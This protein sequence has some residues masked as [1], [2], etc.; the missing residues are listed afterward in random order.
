MILTT[1]RS[2]QIEGF[3]KS[4]S[5]DGFLFLGEQRTGK[6]LTSLLVVDHRK[7]DILFIVC[8]QKAILEWEQQIEQHLKIDWDCQIEIVHYEGCSRTKQQRKVW[9]K[10]IRDWDKAGRRIL[11]IGD[12][13]HRIKK[14]GSFQSRFMRSIAPHCRWRLGLTGT[15]IAQGIQDAWALLEFANPDSAGPSDEFKAR[16]LKYGGYKGKKIVGY[17]HKDEFTELLHR[18]SFRLTLNEARREEGKT[19]VRLRRVKIPVELKPDTWRA[20]QEIQEDLETIVGQSKIRVPLL[21]NRAMKLQQITG[22]Y[23]IHEVRVL[24]RVKKKKRIVTVGEEKLGKL[25]EF[26]NNWPRE[27]KIV[28]CARFTHELDKIQLLLTEL[29]FSFKRISGRVEY[30]NKFDTDAIVLQIQ[31]GIAIDLSAA[32]TYLFY[33]WDHSFINYEQSRFR[34]QSFNTD[35]V[36]YYYLIG[37]NT[38]DEDIY[39]AV[40]RKKDL[41]TLICDKYRRK[42]QCQK[43]H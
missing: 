3:K 34:I 17:F 33:S 41:A 31:S 10:R 42:N 1:P 12:E 22:G 26:L 24:R 21:L 35:Q 9:R 18:Y 36:N 30:D 25:R 39:E 32:N 19:S 2:Y 16:Y 37:T 4:L 28:I 8:P 43:A 13:I 40:T 15:A 20:Y 7:P 38:I 23:L 27:K 5:Y 14:P 6:T 11:V 29:E